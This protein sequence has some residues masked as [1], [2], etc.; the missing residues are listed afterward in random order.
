M[1]IYQQRHTPQ[2]GTTQCLR[3]EQVVDLLHKQR[4]DLI[5]K[6]KDGLLNEGEE[7]TSNIR[8]EVPLEQSASK[9]VRKEL[10][11]KL[12]SFLRR[13]N[14]MWLGSQ[15]G[16]ALGFLCFLKSTGKL[17]KSLLLSYYYYREA[18]IDT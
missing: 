9:N 11:G 6:Q 12:R 14:A 3:T 2:K 17:Y 4:D 1:R 5:Q 7:W 16:V 13:G 10:R 8:I 15:V 18:T